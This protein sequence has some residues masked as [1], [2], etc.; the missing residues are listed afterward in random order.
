MGNYG[1]QTAMGGA[2]AYQVTEGANIGVSVADSPEGGP[3]AVSAQLGY[4]W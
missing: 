4:A 1:G 2:F 3:L